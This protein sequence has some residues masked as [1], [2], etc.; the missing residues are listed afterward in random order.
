MGIKAAI[1]G[2]VLGL[3]LHFLFR[4]WDFSHAKIKL[5]FSFI[6]KSF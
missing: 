5:S 2:V 4:F 3:C 1:L 6:I